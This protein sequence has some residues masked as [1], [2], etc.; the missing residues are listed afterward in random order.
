MEHY[1]QIDILKYSLI[2]TVST[3]L[4]LASIKYY[5]YLQWPFKNRVKRNQ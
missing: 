4:Q 5:C 3:H 1:S 2:I